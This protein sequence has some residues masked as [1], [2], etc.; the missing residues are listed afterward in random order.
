MT[1]VEPTPLANKSSV[2]LNELSDEYV[3]RL[4]TGS[5]L[6]DEQQTAGIVLQEHIRRLRNTLNAIGVNDGIAL[7]KQKKVAA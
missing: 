2:V 5:L 1:S 3:N 6:S 7:D 4:L